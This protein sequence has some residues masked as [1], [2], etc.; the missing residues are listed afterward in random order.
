MTLA[1][2]QSIPDD[3]DKAFG[4]NSIVESFDHAVSPSLAHSLPQL[5][6]AQEW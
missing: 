6:V 2:T 5:G 4:D 1:N 3:L